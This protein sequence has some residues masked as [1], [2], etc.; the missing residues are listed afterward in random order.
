MCVCTTIPDTGV[1]LQ[2]QHALFLMAMVMVMLVVM[3]IVMVMVIMMVL[4]I[5]IIV[6]LMMIF[7][8]DRDVPVVGLSASAF[9]PDSN[10]QRQ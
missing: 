6:V 10:G 8:P 3:V 1:C 9:P 4:V 5:M 2:R 7:L